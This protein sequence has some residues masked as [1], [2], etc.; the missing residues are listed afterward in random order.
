MKVQVSVTWDDGLRTEH[1]Y[2]GSG[3]P[4][5]PE[6]FWYLLVNVGRI[7]CRKYATLKYPSNWR[8]IAF[9][10]EAPIAE[11]IAITKA[12]KENE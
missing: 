11:M 1:F 12:A 8:P 7:I 10:W 4:T 2:E 6:T 9:L 3:L 5:D